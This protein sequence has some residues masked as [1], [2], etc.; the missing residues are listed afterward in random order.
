MV[1]GPMSN[2]DR[3]YNKLSF[4]TNF[5]STIADPDTSRDLALF[6]QQN[7]LS[8][9]GGVQRPVGFDQW[10]ALYNKVRVRGVKIMLVTTS[11][12]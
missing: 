5:N 3:L 4:C 12:S 7:H 8:F 1:R 9:D 2:P 11:R 6:F 10:A